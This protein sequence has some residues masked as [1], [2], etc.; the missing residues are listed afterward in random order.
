MW[1]GFILM[2]FTV[3]IAAWLGLCLIRWQGVPFLPVVT[4]Y[5]LTVIFFPLPCWL[6]IYL[7]RTTLSHH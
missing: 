5:I 2:L 3:M 7:Q 6:F 1:L 4:Q